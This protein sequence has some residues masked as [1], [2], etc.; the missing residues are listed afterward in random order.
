MD[1]YGDETNAKVPFEFSEK[2]GTNFS[3]PHLQNYLLLKYA[4]EL[5]DNIRT[6]G[7]DKQRNIANDPVIS[8][9]LK[10]KLEGAES[11]V[12]I[13]FGFNEDNQTLLDLKG[14]LTNSN[15]LKQVH[16]HNYEGDFQALKQDIELVNK[17][18]NKPFVFR[19]SDKSS[20][21]DAWTKDLM[22]TLVGKPDNNQPIDGIGN[23][24]ENDDL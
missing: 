6:I 10:K 20:I 2:V 7:E 11:M 17:G 12:I 14:V 21:S 3:D 1:L 22:T 24:L 5:S 8:G 19:Y 23:L 13:G 18:R 9:Q 16:W 4:I 15:N